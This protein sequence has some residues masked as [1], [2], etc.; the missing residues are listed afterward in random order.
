M[1]LSTR[2]T[3]AG[4]AL[5]AGTVAG[6]LL[7]A[8]LLHPGAAPPPALSIVELPSPDPAPLPSAT[9]APESPPDDVSR[10][11]T[12]GDHCRLPWLPASYLQPLPGASTAD[13]AQSLAAWLDGRDLPGA[14]PAVEYA[15]GVVFVHGLDDD[16][17]GLPPPR[18]A[19]PGGER[20]C[21]L[22]A[23]WLRSALHDALVHQ[24]ITCCDNVCSVPGGTEGAPS[25]YVVFR[26]RSGDGDDRRWTVAA[27]I[28]L[29][30]LGVSDATRVDDAHFVTAR[31]VRLQAGDCPGEP[32]GAY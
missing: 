6:L 2:V 24:E 28:R 9:A 27:W 4:I 3:V 16:E 30:D 21:G 22:H 17:S 11:D 20:A 8:W 13:L 7:A 25:T 5:A 32:A 14:E 12:S 23:L 31:L 1:H 29:A 19:R 10:V 18:S 26:P 15:R